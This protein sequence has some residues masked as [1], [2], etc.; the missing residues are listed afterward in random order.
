MSGDLKTPGELLQAARK[1]RGLSLADLSAKT[2][3]PDRILE[4][5]E[6]DDYQKVSGALYVKSFLRTYAEYLGLDPQEILDLYHRQPG[7][8]RAEGD[9][10]TAKLQDEFKIPE[11]P[12]PEF[13]PQTIAK[14]PLQEEA[15]GGDV[16]KEDVQVRHV[17]LSSRTRFLLG[18]GLL[19]V[20]LIVAFLVSKGLRRDE[21]E[22]NQSAATPT[23]SSNSTD[24]TSVAPQTTQEGIPAV[25]VE[26]E[27][28]E[29][30]GTDREAPGTASPPARSSDDLAHD[31]EPPAAVTQTA[32]VTTG[33]PSRAA[34][35][36]HLGLPR[37]LRGDSTL[38]FAGGRQYRQVVRV[39]CEEPQAV[40][41]RWFGLR[42][43]RTT[44]WSIDPAPLP[45][46]GIEPGRGY[47]VAEGLV[48]Y[49]G[50]DYD[51]EIKL[52]KITGVTVTL[53][54][55]SLILDEAAVGRWRLLNPSLVDWQ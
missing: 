10:A 19:V 14:P 43:P 7:V 24:T 25:A 13:T 32:D 6:L 20:I 55:R 4:A 42:Q 17:G 30:A 50:A 39:I 2:K 26:N 3:I 23:S 51:I 45:A 11:T 49:W 34:A 12:T 52:P 31:P 29:P 48:V 1:T 9:S 37:A 27:T 15:A 40:E 54:G 8:N 38:V 5:I 33:D 47:R 36:V 35:D 53:N 44:I 21:S 18:L 28:A 41:V 16:W 46:Q 22:L